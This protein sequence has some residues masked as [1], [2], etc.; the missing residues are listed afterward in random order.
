M[1]WKEG[2][3]KDYHPT[4]LPECGFVWYVTYRKGRVGHFDVGPT[5]S[6]QIVL[7][8]LG[9]YA[10]VEKEEPPPWK[11]KQVEDVPI[12]PGLS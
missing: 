5:Q 1:T 4:G 2:G 6:V 3:W 7:R 8:S 9:A 12:P 11:W 10:Q